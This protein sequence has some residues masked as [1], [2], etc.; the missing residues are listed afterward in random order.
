MDTGYCMNCEHRRTVYAG[1]NFKF[2]GCT[3]PPYKGKW[4]AEI[5]IC[6][7]EIAKEKN[8][9]KT[10]MLNKFVGECV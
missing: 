2:L 8:K 1:N 9:W 5:D 3:F 6:P 10:Q 7:E 4:V